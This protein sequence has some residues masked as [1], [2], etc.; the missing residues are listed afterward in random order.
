MQVQPLGAFLLY[1]VFRLCQSSRSCGNDSDFGAQQ[2]V[3][4]VE[5]GEPLPSGAGL[6]AWWCRSGGTV[7][8]V[9]GALSTLVHYDQCR[10]LRI[11]SD[12]D[13]YVNEAQLLN[14]GSSLRES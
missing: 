13:R 6:G 14:E 7:R 2:A 9:M 12:R 4:I 11:L 3:D 5:V 1:P 8:R 10:G